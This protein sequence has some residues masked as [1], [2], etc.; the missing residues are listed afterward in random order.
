MERKLSVEFCC[1]Y[2]TL[3]VIEIQVHIID[4]SLHCWLYFLS[5]IDSCH[6]YRGKAGVLGND[7]SFVIDCIRTLC[8][9]V[10]VCVCMWI[11]HLYLVEASY[12]EA[13]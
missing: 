10:C 4:L 7:G 3:T 11:L 2:D 5:F 13:E 9:C 12:N 8:I 1:I 6:R